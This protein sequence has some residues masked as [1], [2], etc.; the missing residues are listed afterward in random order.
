MNH[1]NQQKNYNCTLLSIGRFDLSFKAFKTLI[2]YHLFLLT[3]G[4][5]LS[6]E[7]LHAM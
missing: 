1:P 6:L 3:V 2:K 7:R 4:S 5:K